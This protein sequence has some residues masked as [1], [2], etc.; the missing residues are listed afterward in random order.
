[1]IDRQGFAV[2]SGLELSRHHNIDRQ[3]DGAAPVRGLLQNRAGG[4]GHLTL[5]QRFADLDPLRD[6]EGVGH[7]AADHQMI[8]PVDQVHQQIQ[9][10]RD[11]GPADHRHD[12]ALRIAK[13][14]VQRLQFGLHQPS[15]ACGQQPRQPLGRGMGAMRGREGV[16]DI[17]PA[18]RGQRGGKGRVVLF[19]A[20]VKAGVFQQCHIARFQIRDDPLGRAAD[21]I[22]GKGHL[23]PQRRLQCGQHHLQAH[24]VHT[25]ALGTIEMGQQDGNAALG[26]NILDGGYDLFDPRGVGHPAILDRDVHVNTGQHGLPVQF[27]IIDRLECGHVA[28]FRAVRRLA[29]CPA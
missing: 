3:V 22:I 11:L 17:G 19:L 6:K 8:H 5:G 4:I 18:K 12:R 2:G 21:A 1:M 25:L 23:L 29:A 27:H 28:S 14:G 24:A 26:L 10:G 9:L 13:G 7:A 20:L 15:G 16:I